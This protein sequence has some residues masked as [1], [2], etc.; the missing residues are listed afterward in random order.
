MKF[1]RLKENNPNV[2]C[3]AWVR[4]AQM[5]INIK[6]ATLLRED[7][8]PES[9]ERF[10]SLW[11]YIENFV[12]KLILEFHCDQTKVIDACQKLG[13][14]HVLIKNFH[15]NFWDIFLG[16][17]IQI[18]IDAHPEKEQKGLTDICKKFFSF[19]VSYMR[20][21]YKKRSQEQLTC[22]RRMNVSK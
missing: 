6:K 5:S 3:K 4:S 15:T 16:N 9:N 10:L 1:F 21:G 22:R 2:F 18:M 7:E 17:L 20:D 19:V 14:R 13:A 8:D 12:D 11:P